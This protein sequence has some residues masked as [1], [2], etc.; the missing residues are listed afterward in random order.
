MQ[1]YADLLAKRAAERHALLVA[2][3]LSVSGQSRSNPLDGGPLE[4]DEERDAQE[5]AVQSGNGGL[6][7][8]A[9]RAKRDT[10]EGEDG[11]FMKLP[12]A[13]AKRRRTEGAAAADDDKVT[14]VLA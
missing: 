1:V 13:A 9:H 5:Q 14:A 3:N 2:T 11:L 4:E 6:A 12:H 7:A 10:A 8:A